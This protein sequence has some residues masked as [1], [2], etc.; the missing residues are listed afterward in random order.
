MYVLELA[1]AQ[2]AHLVASADAC[3]PA[4]SRAWRLSLHP[5]SVAELETGTNDAG[6]V[7]TQPWRTVASTQSWCALPDRPAA[8]GKLLRCALMARAGARSRR[9]PRP[10]VRQP[11]ASARATR[12]P[13]RTAR[14]WP[15]ASA[16][17]APASSRRLG[18]HLMLRRLARTPRSALRQSGWA[19]RPLLR[20]C[21]SRG[22]APRVLVVR[23]PGLKRLRQ[24]WLAT[25]RATMIVMT[26][27][28]TRMCWCALRPPRDG[29]LLG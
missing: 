5:A 13:P 22:R 9:K 27:K 25:A 7:V 28:G 19:A 20:G 16:R 23:T 21:T 8:A 1:C 24:T 18:T 2:M 11:P 29:A 6:A 15:A 14:A 17:P 4:P 26:W 12:R 3:A 10:G